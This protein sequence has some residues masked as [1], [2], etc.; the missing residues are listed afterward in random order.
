MFSREG[1]GRGGEWWE[2]A[3]SVE[4]REFKAFFFLSFSYVSLRWLRRRKV[5]MCVRVLCVL[6]GFDGV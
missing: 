4:I 1:E 6:G 2:E 5:W 3:I